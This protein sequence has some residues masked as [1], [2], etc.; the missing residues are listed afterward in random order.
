MAAA[1]R[2]A[3]LPSGVLRCGDL[4]PESCMWVQKMSLLHIPHPHQTSGR[5]LLLCGCCCRCRC[6]GLAMSFIRCSCCARCCATDLPSKFQKRRVTCGAT[7]PCRNP[8]RRQEPVGCFRCCV[9]GAQ[10]QTPVWHAGGG[11]SHA[12][13]CAQLACVLAAYAWRPVSAAS[14]QHAQPMGRPA[15]EGAGHHHQCVALTQG[16]PPPHATQPPGP[17]ATGKHRRPCRASHN[18]CGIQHLSATTRHPEVQHMSCR[19]PQ[20]HTHFETLPWAAT[21]HLFTPATPPA[22]PTTP[23]TSPSQ[24]LHAQKRPQAAHHPDL[25]YWA[26]PAHLSTLTHQH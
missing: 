6:C 17:G 7:T 3:A 4:K 22:T 19:Y 23:T 1:C 9:T 26:L 5:L 16:P 18:T 13:I 21:H 11:A 10:L 20:F 8:H 15:L 2:S 12:G 25:G 14:V 24:Q